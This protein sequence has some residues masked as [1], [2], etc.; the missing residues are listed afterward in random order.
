MIRVVGAQQLIGGEVPAQIIFR[1][2]GPT[3]SEETNRIAETLEILE[4][5]KKALNAGK[6]LKIFNKWNLKCTQNLNK[7]SVHVLQMKSQLF[8]TIAMQKSIM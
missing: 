8:L 1:K 5:L 3:D 6:H 7:E 4:L 2:E